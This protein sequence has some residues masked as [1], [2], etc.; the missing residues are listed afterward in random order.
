[1]LRMADT[2]LLIENRNLQNRS[3][4]QKF[5]FYIWLLFTLPIKVIGLNTIYLTSHTIPIETN[6]EKSHRLKVLIDVYIKIILMW[7]W[8]EEGR[9]RRGG[10]M[11]SCMRVISNIK[12]PGNITYRY[13][14]Y[15]TFMFSGQAMYFTHTY[16]LVKTTLTTRQQK[17]ILEYKVLCKIISCISN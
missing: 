5:S 16:T 8:R 11:F 6:V 14:M 10:Y 3:R 12:Y 7:V 2:F 1:M 9:V 17:Q 4:P 15:H 13:I